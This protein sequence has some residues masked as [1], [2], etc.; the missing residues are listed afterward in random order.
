MDILSLAS[1]SSGNAYVVR[2]GA[3]S[4]LLDAGLSGKQTIASLRG[5][6]IDPA[7]VTAI[8]I[9]H[10]HNDHISGAGVLCRRLDI[11]LYMTEGTR[12]GAMK[13]LGKI[14]AGK[15]R[16][17]APR[18]AFIVNGLEILALPVCHDAIEPVNYIFDA[19]CSR[20]AVLT[21]TGYVSEELAQAMASCRAIVLEANHDGEMLARGPYPWSLKQRI[22]SR[23]GHL[24][25][26]QAARVLAKLAAK[27]IITQVHLGH[28][29]A[30]NNSPTA[31]RTTVAAYLRELGMEAEP[32]Y[33]SIKTL[34]RFGRGPLLQIK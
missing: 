6:G 24:S 26:A 33:Q 11:P 15:L 4:L 16:I 19:G 28:L 34:P 22:A 5:A 27:G 1:G 18:K 8:L 32:V 29:S 17:I 30:V 3:Q 13:K 7:S 2:N 21:D 12:R 10:E 25:N 31:A 14:A 9:T 23:R 20:G